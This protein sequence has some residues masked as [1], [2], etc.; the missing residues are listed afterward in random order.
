MLGEGIKPAFFLNIE[1]KNREER[2]K[3]V[4]DYQDWLY[5]SGLNRIRVTF[6]AEKAAVIAI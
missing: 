2:G 1:T 6:N 5:E 3:R 4:Q